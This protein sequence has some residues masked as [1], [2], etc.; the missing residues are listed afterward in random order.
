MEAHRY[1]KDAARD[2]HL[3]VVM[4]RAMQSVERR[5]FA[6]IRDA[7][8][9]PAQFDVLEV[10]YHK[11]PLTVN[12]LIEKT[13]SSSGN[14][15]VVLENLLRHGLVAKWADESDRRIRHVELTDAGRERMDQYFPEHVKEV[16][17]VFA[18]LDTKET[19]TLAG[20]MKKLG[21][22]L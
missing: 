3:L 1:G 11:G 20:L 21:K 19:E 13:L 7:E 9:T 10:L 4:V 14:T 16:Q 12:E 2:L 15:G 5:L 6:H 18:A 17:A 22:S 8:F